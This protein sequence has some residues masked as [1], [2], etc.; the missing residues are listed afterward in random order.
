MII[1]NNIISPVPELKG[2]RIVLRALTADDEKPLRELTDNENVYRY[3]PAFLYEQKYEDKSYVIENLYDECLKD[4]LILGVYLNDEFTGLVEVYGFRPVLRKASVGYRLLERY[5][6][7]GIATDA[8]SLIRDYLIN[9]KDIR[10]ITASTMIDNEASANVL[11]KNGF[12]HFMYTVFEN[13]GYQK[14]ILTEK[15]VY[16]SDDYNKQYSFH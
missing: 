8:L 11:K 5:W 13:W 14:L 9:E 1:L 2:E 15:W 6:G 3:L 12:R 7:M 10:V 16:T 4:S